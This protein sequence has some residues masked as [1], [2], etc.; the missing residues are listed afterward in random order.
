MALLEEERDN[1]QG[2]GER[3]EIQ[4]KIERVKREFKERERWIEGMLF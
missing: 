1:A 3:A 2:E 4:A